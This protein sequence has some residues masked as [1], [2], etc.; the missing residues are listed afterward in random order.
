L[1]IAGSISGGVIAAV[2][3]PGAGAVALVAAVADAV[4]RIQEHVTKLDPS[5]L[6][7]YKALVAIQKREMAQGPGAVHVMPEEIKA[8]LDSQEGQAPELDD[9]ADLLDAMH[10]NEVVEKAEKKG[11]A[12][13]AAVI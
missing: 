3:A 2:A 7:I 5:E 12:A 4:Q 8:Y 13:F 11:K 10:D 1:I 6:L 9:I